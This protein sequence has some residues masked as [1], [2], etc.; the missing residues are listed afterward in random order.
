MRFCQSKDFERIVISFK[1]WFG[2]FFV[3]RII[4]ISDIPYREFAIHSFECRQE[5]WGW[6]IIVLR[7]SFPIFSSFLIFLFWI[8]CKECKKSGKESLHLHCLKWDG[9]RRGLKLFP[10]RFSA[11]EGLKLLVRP[12]NPLMAGKSPGVNTIRKPSSMERINSAIRT[13]L[14]KGRKE[15]ICSCVFLDSTWAYTLHYRGVQVESIIWQNMLILP[16][17]NSTRYEW[18]NWSL[19]S[20]K[21]V[22]FFNSLFEIFQPLRGHTN[23]SK[24]YAKIA[25]MNPF[26]IWNSSKNFGKYAS[27]YCRVCSLHF[28]FFPSRICQD[29][30]SICWWIK[31]DEQTKKKWGN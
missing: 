8:A 15:Q 6:Q 28:P 7:D 5:S 25:S 22:F 27:A 20:M 30:V 2:K 17:Q 13:V 10:N 29:I 4:R 9:S 31:K 16:M 24:C 3:I 18:R 21:L 1:I 23:S 19:P 12:L 26:R 11:V 14:A